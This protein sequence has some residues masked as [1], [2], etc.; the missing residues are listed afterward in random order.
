MYPKLCLML[1]SRLTRWIGA[2]IPSI[3]SSMG[4]GKQMETRRKAVILKVHHTYTSLV[5]TQRC[6]GKTEVKM[7]NRLRRTHNPKR[8]DKPL[9]SC[10][11][12]WNRE[13]E[14]QPPSRKLARRIAHHWALTGGLQALE[15]YPHLFDPVE[16]RPQASSTLAIGTAPA[17]D[18]SS[19]WP[20]A[21]WPRRPLRG[22]PASLLPSSSMSPPPAADRLRQ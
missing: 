9:G 6:M 22:V 8:K 14:Q 5:C 16:P 12:R 7:V 15:D 18:S 21:S 11:R 4:S 10:S 1:D 19:L 20:L 17:P 2:G 3:C 13:N